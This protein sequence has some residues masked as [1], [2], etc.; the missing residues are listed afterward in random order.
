MYGAEHTFRVLDI[1]V[2]H[3][4]GAQKEHG[5]TRYVVDKVSQI[6]R[7]NYFYHRLPLIIIMFSCFSFA[8]IDFQILPFILLY[9]KIKSKYYMTATHRLFCGIIF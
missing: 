6:R 3:N 1:V 5:F 2:K 9:H 8:V 7:S 4:V